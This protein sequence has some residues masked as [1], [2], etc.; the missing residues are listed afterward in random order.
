MK[1]RL[2]T[3]AVIAAATSLATGCSFMN[4]QTHR[5][6]VVQEKKTEYNVTNGSSE[7]KNRLV[8]SCGVFEVGDSLSGGFS[9]YDT[10]SKLKE[11]K[12]YDIQ[13]GGFRIGVFSQ[14]PTVTGITEVK[15][16]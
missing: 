6:C 7:R 11:G 1:K 3:V 10:W 12:S 14:F 4:E 13:T 5:G 15:A 2:F 16:G 8:T 9:S